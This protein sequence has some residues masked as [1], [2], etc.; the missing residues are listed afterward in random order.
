MLVFHAP[1]DKEN[2]LVEVKIVSV[3]IPMAKQTC[4]PKARGDTTP[5]EHKTGPD[6]VPRLYHPKSSNLPTDGVLMQ[7]KENP[8]SAFVVLGA[9]KATSPGTHWRPVPRYKT[10]V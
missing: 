7:K 1:S 4:R 8:T 10:A 5:Q 2:T 6:L 3:S 9:E